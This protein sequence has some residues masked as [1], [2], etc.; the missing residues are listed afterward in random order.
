MSI[1][2]T[3]VPEGICCTTDMVVSAAVDVRAEKYLPGLRVTREMDV[4]NTQPGVVRRKGN[5]NA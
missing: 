1:F 5:S 2:K 3:E 4:Q